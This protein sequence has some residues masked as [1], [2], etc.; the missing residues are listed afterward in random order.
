MSPTHPAMTVP[1][2][3]P[4]VYCLLAVWAIL[5]EIRLR[6][7]REFP[8]CG[9]S[10]HEDLAHEVVAHSGMMKESLNTMPRVRS[11]DLRERVTRLCLPGL[12][13]ADPPKQREQG[14]GA[15]DKLDRRRIGQCAVR[16]AAGMQIPI[17][18]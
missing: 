14:S 11:E 18:C 13:G 2:E 4:C 7:F 12:A 10:S 9:R 17:A 5:Q 16:W 1:D 15:I 8:S 6:V 3:W